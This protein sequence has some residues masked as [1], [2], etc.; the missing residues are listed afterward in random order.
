MAAMHWL[1]GFARAL[2]GSHG[3]PVWPPET[4]TPHWMRHTCAT[5]L[6]ENDGPVWEAAGYL[7]MTVEML[8]RKYGH[9]RPNHHA[10]ARS[11]FTNTKD[12]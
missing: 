8:E 9:H 1:A 11:A 6:M 3:T 5:L 10:S 12:Q 2:K 7:G 4:L